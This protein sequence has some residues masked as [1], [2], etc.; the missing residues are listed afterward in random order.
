LYSNTVV[1]IKKQ[2]LSVEDELRVIKMFKNPTDLGYPE[3][4]IDGSDGLILR[5]GGYAGANGVQGIAEHEEEMA[6]HHDFQWQLEH[7]PSLIWLH[8]IH[9]AEGSKTSWVNNLLSYKDLD[10]KTKDLLGTLTAVM[11]RDTDFNVGKFYED[12]DGTRWPHGTLLEGYYPNI[13][14]EDR[15]YFPFN[16]IYNFRGMSREDSKSIII[17]MIKHITQSKYQYTHEWD[18][19]DIIISDQWSSLHMRWPCKNILNRLLH[20]AT[21]DYTIKE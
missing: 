15:L 3:I 13:I 21:F 14:R 11:L 16:Q 2:K 18:N 4:S 12:I 7:K 1:V 17:P 9:G 20:R 6:W 10:Q 8:A 5:V 19:G